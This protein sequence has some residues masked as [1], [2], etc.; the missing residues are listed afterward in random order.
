MHL[1]LLILA[2]QLRTGAVGNP[3]PAVET[4]VRVSR[5]DSA[6]DLDRAHSA[7]ASFERSRRA[8]LPYSHGG[9]GRC[10]VRL[11]RYCWWYDG[12]VPA[13]PPEA[14]TIGQR[15]GELLAELDLLSARY[16]GDD[17]LA[18]MR[19]HYRVDGGRLLAADSAAQACGATAWWCSALVGYA[20]HA[21][22]EAARADSAFSLATETMNGG[23]ACAWRNIAPL[24]NSND[25]DAYEHLACDARRGVETRYWLTS[26]P[27]LATVANEWHNEFNARRV[28]IRHAEHAATPHALSWGDD[29]AELVLRNGWPTAWS[30]VE[31]YGAGTREPNIIGHDPSPS[32]TFAPQAR[33]ADSLRALAPGDWDLNA[34]RGEARYAPRLVRRVAGVTAQVARFRRGD[35]TL[36]VA[37]FAASDD[38]LLAPAATLAA[39][40]ADGLSAVNQPDTTRAGRAR[41]VIPGVP[42]LVG[43][44]VADTITHT[45]ARMRFGFAPS[46]DSGRL[47]LSDL[48][49]YRAGEEPATSLD[50]ALARTIAGDTVT[51]GRPLGLF[52]EMY[53]LID[54]ESIDLAVSVE[55]V[56]H[57]WIRSA[58]QR[59]GLTPVDTPIRIRWS[60]SR[61]L[62]SGGAAAHAISLDL[63]NL[64]AGRYRLTL[65]ATPLGGTPAATVREIE[66][67]N[68]R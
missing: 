66:V 27:Q 56:D 22:G 11:G 24:L 54:G 58:R 63:E 8:L 49:A 13:F 59:L 4:P 34:P 2:F 17:W 30:R 10:E 55:R 43:V 52:W 67:Q 35:S 64:E 29:A 38:S 33:L 48:L 68:A 26:R 50:S 40:R 28:L 6:R 23:D 65:T 41:V 21:R 14:A 12:T 7:Q 9:E 46:A 44:E 60:D 53:G 51:R 57:G 1:P 42:L 31:S 45:L 5:A 25:R 18:G 62:A 19:V 3:P 37:A 61:P 32:F 20:A 36:V 15:R 47:S 39:T 16:P